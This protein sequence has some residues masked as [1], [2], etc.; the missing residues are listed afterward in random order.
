MVRRIRGMLGHHLEVTTQFHNPTRCMPLWSAHHGHE[1]AAIRQT[2]ERI[3]AAL[4]KADC[5]LNFR[6]DH[7]VRG[8]WD[9]LRLEQVF[10]NLFSNAIKYAAGST[11]SV[12]VIDYENE[13]TVYFEDDG[14]GIPKESRSKIFDRFERAGQSRKIGGLGLGLYVVREI[15]RAHGGTIT[16]DNSLEKG[17]KFKI[18]LPKT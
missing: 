6:L 17:T 2:V 5:K 1:E 14:C 12:N 4:V 8:V 16:L 13:V 18:G 9:T 11:I 3:S 15:I 10:E 7:D